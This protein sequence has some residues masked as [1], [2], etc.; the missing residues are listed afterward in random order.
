MIARQS[1][2]KR[3]ERVRGASSALRVLPASVKNRVLRTLANQI[4]ANREK[5]FRANRQDLAALPEGTSKAFRDRLAQSEERLRQMTQS[6]NQV[7]SF[8]DPNGEVVDT[9][10]LANGLKAKRMRSP[11]GVILMIFESRPDVA[12][13][14]FSLAFKSGNAIILRGGKESM[15]T[16]AAIY[17]L[18]QST[19]A[20]F[21]ISTDVFW[22]IT[23]ADRRITTFLLK[24]SKLIDIVVPRGGDRLIDF[25]VNNTRIPIIKND[26]GMCHIYVHDDADL[27]MATRVV[28]NAKTQRPG[29]C[30]AMETLLVHRDVASVLLPKLYEA[31]KTHSV[32]WR[33]CPKSLNILRKF[34]DVRA[35]G[36]DDFDTEYL[37][38]KINCRIVDGLDAAIEHIERH[39]SRH[40][41]S[42][43]TRSRI[44]ARQFQSAIDAA[45][46]YSNASTRFT[47]GFALGLGGELGISTQKLHV[48]GPVG[49]RELTSVRWIIDGTGQVRE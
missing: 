2:L 24:Q 42:I 41:E 37:D 31:M 21:K 26:R 1:I 38:L 40:S 17:A 8:D 18:L 47:D 43:I 15:R 32:E 10:T 29:V 20:K 48:R 35:A 44:V 13:E 12:V 6:L 16:T 22:G 14:A 46:V 19:L 27:V 30:N 11:L 39:G 9:R 23:D 49:L 3:L 28:V 33:V 34:A 5:L 45:V 25:V 4:A 7:A 36:R